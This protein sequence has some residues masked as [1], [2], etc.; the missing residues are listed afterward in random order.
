MHRRQVS[1]KRLSSDSCIVIMN[2]TIQ[3]NDISISR[4]Y[5]NFL[6]DYLN[7]LGIRVHHFLVHETGNTKSGTTFDRMPV[8]FHSTVTG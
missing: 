2:T 3:E 8:I 7:F 5:A 1:D 6:T 4:P